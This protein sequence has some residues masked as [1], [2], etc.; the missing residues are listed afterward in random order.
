MFNLVVDVLIESIK[1]EINDK[2]LIWRNNFKDKEFW[3]Y[4]LEAIWRL[5]WEIK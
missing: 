2:L 4:N 3:I 5:N 1:E